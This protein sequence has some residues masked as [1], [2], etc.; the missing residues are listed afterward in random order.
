VLP[1]KAKK[2]ATAETVNEP[3]DLERL[4]GTFG[5]NGNLLLHAPQDDCIRAELVGS[6]TCQAAGLAARGAAPVT[7]LCRALIEAGHDP[8]TPLEVWRG[9]MLALRV[10]SIGAGSRLTVEDDRHGR[11]RFRL[12]RDRGCGAASPVAENDGDRRLSTWAQVDDARRP[13]QA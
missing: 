8:A 4:G 6:G 3:L 10:R 2:P 5:V 9:D 1:L 7:S 11:P 12:W 13:G